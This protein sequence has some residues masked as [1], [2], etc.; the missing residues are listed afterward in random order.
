VPQTP[1]EKAFEEF[2]DSYD[3][4][5]A[6]ERPSKI[7]KLMKNTSFRDTEILTEMLE[8]FAVP[9]DPEPQKEKS[10]NPHDRTCNCRRCPHREELK[11]IDDFYNRFLITPDGVM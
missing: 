9:G 8:T 6:F 7:R 2:L 4:L 3:S 11:R 10:D 5:D 1:F